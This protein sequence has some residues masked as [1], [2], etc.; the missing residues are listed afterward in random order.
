LAACGNQAGSNNHVEQNQQPVQIQD[1]QA[2]NESAEESTNHDEWSSLPEYDAIMQNIDDKDYTFKAVTDNQ[3]KRILLLANEDGKEQ[4]KTI[5]IKNTSLLKI[6]R[7]DGNKQI[8]NAVLE[9]S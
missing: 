8:F 1:V 2:N 9:S 4:Y 6:I 7:L 5:F 3:G